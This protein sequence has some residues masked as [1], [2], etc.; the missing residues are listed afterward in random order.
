MTR[1]IRVFAVVGTAAVL[2][3]ACNGGNG[4]NSATT[5]PSGLPT[6]LASEIA[7]GIP[8]AIPSGL[9]PSGIPT[10]IP[11]GLL[12]SGIPTGIPTGIAGALSTGTAH[13]EFSGAQS[14]TL[15]LPLKTGT[16]V[17]GAAMGL[18]YLD[19]SADSFALGGVAE[20]GTVKTSTVFTLAATVRSP[21]I[22]VTSTQG[23]C[24]VTFTEATPTSVK[25]T[26]DCQNLSGGINLTATFDASSG[27]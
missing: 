25:G 10:A 8:T 2:M 6:G 1:F 24:T 20:T 7:S 13:L 22:A 14:A 23:E 19:S 15:D 9:L 26:A 16:Y 21:L 27:G 11:S 4:N 18:A 3:A 17:T 5:L 12:P